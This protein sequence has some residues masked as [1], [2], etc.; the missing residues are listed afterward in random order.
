MGLDAKNLSSE[1]VNNTGVDQ[2]PH[3][4]SLISAFVFRFLESITSKVAIN[5]ISAF[6]LVSVAEQAGLNLT[7]SKIPKTGFLVLRP[8]YHKDNPILFCVLFL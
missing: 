4:R 7:L 1:V 5:E 2:P 6:V 3:P 8:N